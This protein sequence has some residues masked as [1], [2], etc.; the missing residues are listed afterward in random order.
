MR[1]TLSL[2][3]SL[4]IS[5]D[6]ESFFYEAVGGKKTASQRMSLTMNPNNESFYLFIYLIRHGSF[7][8]LRHNNESC[9]S[10]NIKSREHPFNNYASAT[11]FIVFE[12]TAMGLLLIHCF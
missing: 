2:S 1:V 7:S 6:T 9:L 10:V 5:H 12:L 8:A 4:A 11:L 3:I